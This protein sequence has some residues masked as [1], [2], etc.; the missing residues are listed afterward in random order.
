MAAKEKDKITETQA[1]E[2]SQ[3]KAEP[4][5]KADMLRRH[6][7]ELFGISSSTWDGAFYGVKKD[8][9]TIDEARARI[10]EWLGKE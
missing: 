1:A 4:V 10:N 3:K 7:A 2:P 8:E 5:Y 9:M 6:C